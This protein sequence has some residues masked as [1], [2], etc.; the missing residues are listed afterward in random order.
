MHKIVYAN[1]FQQSKI[2]Q[3]DD[4]N[5]NNA[6]DPAISLDFSENKN[7][8]SC[9]KFTSYLFF[10]ISGKIY[11]GKIKMPKKRAGSDGPSIF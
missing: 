2:G 8:I 3:S 11:L 1:E 5:P 10:P 6:K 7:L 9:L 4:Q